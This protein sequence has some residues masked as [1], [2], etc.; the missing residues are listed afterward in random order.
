[1]AAVAI[2]VTV[3]SSGCLVV[4]IGAGGAGE[5]PRQRTITD[6]KDWFPPGKILVVRV[7]GEISSEGAGDVLGLSSE[8][9]MP[10]RIAEEL[11][12]ASKDSDIKAMLLII[13]S[14]GGGVTASDVIYETLAAYKKDTGVDV[15]AVMID[16]AASGGYYVAMAADRIYA[17]PT[18]ITG[19]IGVIASLPSVE[20]LADWAGYEQRDITSGPNKAIGS[21]FR[22]FTPEQEK[23]LQDMVDDMYA[24]FL[25]VVAA[26]R[27]NIPQEKLRMLADGRIY[28]AKQAKEAGLIDEIGNVDDAIA[29]IEAKF[30]GSMA[31]VTYDATYGRGG[32]L[33]RMS[34]PRAASGGAAGVAALLGR[35][36]V[37]PSRIEV[38]HGIDGVGE[39]APGFYYLWQP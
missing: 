25:E 29:A 24:R 19:S 18:T 5:I 3:A 20:K 9:G 32:S 14:P 8:V 34:A 15:T 10:A 35:G 11:R 13:N 26:G 6:S 7:A 12:H 37:V 28:T 4:P 1:M 36:A 38:R 2:A 33:Y 30:E 17:H 31:V 22:P 23:I 21:M 39:R 16:T 27:P